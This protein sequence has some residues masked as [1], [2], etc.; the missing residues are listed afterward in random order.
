ML[1][2]VLASGCGLAPEYLVV[3]FEPDVG[4]EPAGE[5]AQGEVPGEL[6]PTDIAVLIEG[7]CHGRVGEIIPLTKGSYE[8]SVD[9]VGAQMQVVRLQLTAPEE[10]QRVT[11][12]IAAGE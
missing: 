8:V 11:I 7:E 10:P 9:V 4:F 6:Q 12:R 2:L 1:A 3:T 5:C